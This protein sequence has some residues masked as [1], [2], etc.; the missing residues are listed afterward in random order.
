MNCIGTHSHQDPL[1][2]NASA[3]KETW[4]HL[5]ACHRLLEAEFLS[6]DKVDSMGSPVLKNINDGFEYFTSW[7]STLIEEGKHEIIKPHAL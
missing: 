4:E 1:P 3:T 7:L 5:Q 2:E 6:H